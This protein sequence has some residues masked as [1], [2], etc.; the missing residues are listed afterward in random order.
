MVERFVNIERKIFVAKFSKVE[1][2]AWEKF[3]IVALKSKTP[4]GYNFTDGGEDTVGL[5]RTPEHCAKIAASHL[6]KHHTDKM[7]RK[8]PKETC[9]K[10][11][12]AEKGIPKSLECC[13]KISATQRNESPFK[14][15]LEKLNDNLLTYI[16][17]AKLFFG[18]S[19]EYLLQRVD[20]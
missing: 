17:L 1:M 10:I 9:E 18:K 2:D 7:K 19:A 8:L 15:L 11:G 20:N 4:Y 6:G 5:E 14:N 12:A 13:V 16:K 3:F